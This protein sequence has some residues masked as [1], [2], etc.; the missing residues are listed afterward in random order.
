MTSKHEDRISRIHQL[1]SPHRSFLQCQLKNKV[2]STV[3]RT[4]VAAATEGYLS[5]WWLLWLFF[6]LFMSVFCCY[7]HYTVNVISLYNN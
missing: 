1:S 6:S 4:A 2:T 5:R 3:K 7:R